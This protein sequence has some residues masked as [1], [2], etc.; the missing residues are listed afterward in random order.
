M[1]SPAHGAGAS[2]PFH[3]KRPVIH[4]HPTMSL[5]SKMCN[6]ATAAATRSMA[7]PTKPSR[8][9]GGEPLTVMKRDQKFVGSAMIELLPDREAHPPLHPC[10]GR[11]PTEVRQFGDHEHRHE[12]PRGACN[13]PDRVAGRHCGGITMTANAATTSSA[14]PACDPAHLAASITD[15]CRVGTWST[16]AIASAGKRKRA[17]THGNEPDAGEPQAN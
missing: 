17:P 7:S 2:L 14:R 15:W 6:A 5:R 1:A 8:W 10:R 3:C 12:R 11:P 13:G 4:C 9:L 16:S